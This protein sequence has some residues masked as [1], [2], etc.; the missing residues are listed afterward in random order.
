MAEAFQRGPRTPLKKKY[1]RNL[2]EICQGNVRQA[3]RM[4]GKYRADFYELVKK[5]GLNLADFKKPGS[6]CRKSL[7]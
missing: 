4:A 2:L 3:A 5:H 1:L 6:G 7:P